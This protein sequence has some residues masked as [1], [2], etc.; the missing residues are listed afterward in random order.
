MQES[1]GAREAL[2]RFYEAFT[3]AVSGDMDTF[4]VGS[5]LAGRAY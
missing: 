1:P 4:D 3:E 5:S 2:I